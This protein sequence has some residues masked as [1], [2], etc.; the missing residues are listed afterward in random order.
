VSR[1]SERLARLRA[2]LQEDEQVLVIVPPEWARTGRGDATGTLVYDDRAGATSAWITSTTP[3]LF[4]GGSLAA[5]ER[6]LAEL[7]A[8]AAA[9]PRRRTRSSRSPR[10]AR[11]RSAPADGAGA[12]EKAGA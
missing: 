7:R 11:A 1:I 5:Q 12:L 3:G 4:L 6:A 9:T 8:E 2:A 10:A